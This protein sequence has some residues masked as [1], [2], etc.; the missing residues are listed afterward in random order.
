MTDDL[1]RITELWTNGICCSQVMAVMALESQG[2]ANP[3]L[4][5]AMKAL[6]GG[7]AGSGDICGTLTGAGCVLSMCAARGSEAETDHPQLDLML[8]DLVDW[9]KSEYETLYG[10]IRCETILQGYSANAQI[11]CPG[12]MAATWEKVKEILREYGFAVQGTDT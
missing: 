10:G 6:C 5:R 4:V 9:F 12:I 11:R 7:F 2:K 1:N 3:D 8:T